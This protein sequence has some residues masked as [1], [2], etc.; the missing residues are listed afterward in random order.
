MG[1]SEKELAA[2]LAGRWSEELIN[3]LN[4]ALEKGNVDQ[5]SVLDPIDGRVDLRG[6]LVSVIIKHRKFER[7]DFSH[8]AW[9]LAGQFLFSDLQDCCFDYAELGANLDH[10]FFKCSF[11]KAK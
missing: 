1:S 3:A 9:I 8:S 2:T 6:L 10:K 7:I 5:L 11:L 4:K